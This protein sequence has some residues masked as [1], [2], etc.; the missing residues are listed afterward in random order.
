MK[1]T[2]YIS[3]L[4][5]TLLTPRANLSPFAVQTLLRLMR[6]G[7]LFTVATART[8][9]STGVLLK[10]ILPL[11]VP[12]VLL[13]G[14][15]VYDT[16]TDQ[17]VKKAVLPGE[18]VLELLRLVKSHGQTGFLYSIREGFIRPFH[19]DISGRPFLQAFLAARTGYY[20]FTPTPDLALHA[21][22]DI[23]YLTMQDTCGALAPLR[24]AVKA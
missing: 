24:E 6:G 18:R 16:R 9:Q 1:T 15:L 21:A 11:P 20:T 17:Y 19:E 7:L 14:A 22:E 23:V 2:L 5:G 8:W 12:A 3:D 10:D 4:D 13:N